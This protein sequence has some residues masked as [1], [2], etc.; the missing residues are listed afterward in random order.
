MRAYGRVELAVERAQSLFGVEHQQPLDQTPRR[1]VEAF[2][3]IVFEVLDLAEYEILGAG[4]ERRQARNHL[5][6]DGAKC[7]EVRGARAVAAVRQQLGGDVLGGADEAV[8]ARRRLLVVLV[9]VLG[10]DFRRAKVR[11]LDVHV[12]IQEDVLG[13]QIAVHNAEAVH[14]LERVQNLAGV[15]LRTRRVKTAHFVYMGKEFTVFR[16]RQHEIESLD[17]LERAVDFYEKW[18]RLALSTAE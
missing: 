6:D 16:V 9:L 7:P 13:L 12:L 18:T 17:V 3:E 15:K 10:H 5:I 1:R 14:V 8:A 2:R 4:A 11:D